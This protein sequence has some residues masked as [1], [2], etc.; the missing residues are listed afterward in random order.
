MQSRTELA[1]EIRIDQPKVSVVIPTLNEEKNLPHV[2]PRVP[3]WVHEVII[4]DGRS[5][6]RTVEVAQALWPGVRIVHQ[7]GRGKGDAVRRDAHTLLEADCARAGIPYVG[8]VEGHDVARGERAQGVVAAPA[9]VVSRV[10]VGAAL[11]DDDLAGVDGL[12]AEAL[13]A[14]TLRVGVASVAGARCALLVCHLR[15]FP[16][17]MSVTLTAVSS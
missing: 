7:T 10:E 5:T 14:Q 4:V 6:D 8:G 1:A 17:L 12:A 9:D 11:A 2:L 3:G 15:H 13:D 16:G